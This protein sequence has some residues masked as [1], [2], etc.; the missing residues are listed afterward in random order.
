MSFDQIKGPAMS[1]K[2]DHIE[3]TPDMIAAGFKM[4]VDSGVLD[5]GTG[6]EPLTGALLPDGSH[7]SDEHLVADIYRAMIRARPGEAEPQAKAG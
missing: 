4:L 6:R 2:P 3:V 5:H 1:G 7:C